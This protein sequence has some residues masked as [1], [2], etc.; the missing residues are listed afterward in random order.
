MGKYPEVLI[1]HTR[2]GNKE[3]QQRSISQTVWS[4][5]LMNLL[6]GKTMLQSNRFVKPWILYVS[7]PREYQYTLVYKRF[8]EVP[9][10][11]KPVTHLHITLAPLTLT[12]PWHPSHHSI[13]NTYLYLSVSEN[14]VQIIFKSKTYYFAFTDSKSDPELQSKRKKK[15]PNQANNAN[16]KSLQSWN[17]PV[18][19]WYINYNI[20]LEALHK[21]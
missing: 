14:K 20:K 19:H 13:P 18:P 5:R 21:I 11:K 4:E 16:F 17:L 15:A 10:I 7:P 9:V 6:R 2:R 1:C 8:W 3:L 12:W